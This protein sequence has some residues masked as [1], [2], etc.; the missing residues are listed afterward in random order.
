MVTSLLNQGGQP[1][2][3]IVGATGVNVSTGEF[4]I[5][6]GKIEIN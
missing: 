2:A 6:K 5:F 3:S 4:Y 1:G